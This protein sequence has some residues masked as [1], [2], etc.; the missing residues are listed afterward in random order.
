MQDDLVARLRAT[1]RKEFQ[2]PQSFVGKPVPTA[3]NLLSVQALINPDGPDAA[4]RIEELSSM[5]ECLTAELGDANARIA[6]LEAENER[7]RKLTCATWFYMPDE[8]DRCWFSPHEVIDEMYDPEPGNHVFEVE[9]ATSLPSIWCA[10]R[11]TDDPDA[12]ERFTFTEHA[13]EAEA[14]AALE[15]M[16]KE[17]AE[18]FARSGN[19]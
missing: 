1:M 19:V 2:A 11:V 7:L 4:D 16:S 17:N 18:T 9:C 6:A 12:D 8:G 10:V 15:P 14:R 5:E 13:T 3:I